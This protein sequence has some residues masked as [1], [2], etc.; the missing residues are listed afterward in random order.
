MGLAC[1]FYQGST[2]CSGCP[3]TVAIRNILEVAGKETVV[4]NA[5]SCLEIVSSQYPHTSWGVNYIHGAFE[6]SSA[7]A[8]GVSLAL[9]KMGKKGNVIAIA[10]DGG[11]LDIGLQSLSG[12][13][14]RGDRIC[15]ICLDNNAYM[16]TGIQR[17]SA[18]PFGAWTTTSPHGKFSVGKEEWKKPIMEIVASH[19]TPYAATASVGFIPDLKEK[20]RKA[21]ER[22]NQPS[23]L[24]VECPC[25]LGWKFDPS[26]TIEIA[27]LAVE[28]GMW[29]LYETEKGNFRITR[30]VEKRRP[31]KEYLRTQG[32]FAHL[33]KPGNE[34]VIKRIQEQ[35]DIEW[36]KLLK[37]SGQ[38]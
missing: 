31:V 4:V 13:L 20:V 12:S 7:I 33:F 6:N 18:T 5:T 2:N 3:E 21:L 32:R 35:V 10:G 1:G 11:T 38:K 37:L 25:P 17:S 23:F 34:R 27:R 16:N 22:K 30:P 28:T 9:E 15:F 19:R 8:S 29:M 36:G 24:H 26:K 14:E